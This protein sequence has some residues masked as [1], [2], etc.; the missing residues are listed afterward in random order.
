[1]FPYHL[2]IAVNEN[3]SGF[4]LIKKYIGSYNTDGKIYSTQYSLGWLDIFT[5]LQSYLFYSHL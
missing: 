3:S 1:M 4:I 5:P 2:K